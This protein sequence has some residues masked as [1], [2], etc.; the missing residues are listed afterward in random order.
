MGNHAPATPPEIRSLEDCM[1]KP[2]MPSLG[3]QRPAHFLW[4]HPFNPEVTRELIK[5]AENILIYGPPKSR[6]SFLLNM[7]VVPHFRKDVN[8][9][10]GF[11]VNIIEE[12]G[13]D[14]PWA[15]VWFDTE[16]SNDRVYETSRRFYRWCNVNPDDG[17][18]N[19]FVFYLRGMGHKEK[20]EKLIEGLEYV[21]KNYN[22]VT[23]VLDQ[24]VDLTN[25]TDDTSQA[26][27][28][29]TLIQYANVTFGTSVVTSMHSN[30]QG[31][32]TNGK[33]GSYFDKKFE[34]TLRA[35]IVD[36]QYFNTKITPRNLRRGLPNF[37]IIFNQQDDMPLM[38]D[39][40]YYEPN[41]T[42]M[43]AP[44]ERRDAA[45]L[46]FFTS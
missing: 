23:T 2:Y 24:I 13:N 9:S 30:R 8:I 44:P 42:A 3:I 32:E 14:K 26:E 12:R 6:K 31:R 27:E 28:V 19:F 34:C 5:P 39:I 33:V 45:S 11:D 10:M 37:N 46:D 1:I 36:D 29:M 40:G 38:L 43:T 20:R 16:Q 41:L 18:D 25:G 7:M 22:V 15:V 21:S 4:K 17:I 35:N